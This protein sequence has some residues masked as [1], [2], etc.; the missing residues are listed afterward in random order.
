MSRLKLTAQPR[1]TLGKEVAKLRREGLLP[2]VVYGAGVESQSIQLDARDFGLLHRQAGRHAVLDLE[3]EGDGKP[4]PV[5]L[6]A[7]QVHPVTRQ[8]LHIDLLAVNLEEE[9]TV[10]AAIVMVGESNAV[11]RLGGV[12]LHLRDSVSVRAKP[13]DLP[14]GI[15]LDI[16]PLEDFDAV[17]HVSDLRIPPG[18]TLITELSEPIARVQPPRVEEEPVATAEEAEAAEGEE[19]A[20]AEAE[21]AAESGEAAETSTEES[22]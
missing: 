7:V 5:L 2:G 9:R 10:D 1:D 16:T 12:L 17:L 8:P 15:E 11:A 21:A 20:A 3:I 4:R 13:D 19:A 18:V 14:S 22:A 6:Q